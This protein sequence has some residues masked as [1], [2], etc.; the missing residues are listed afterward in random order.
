MDILPNPATA[1]RLSESH[2]DKAST[3]INANFVRGYNEE[4][5][6]HYIAAMGWVSNDTVVYT[7]A[8]GR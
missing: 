6:Q 4:D 1:V 7:S 2:G 8:V 3:Y 5:K